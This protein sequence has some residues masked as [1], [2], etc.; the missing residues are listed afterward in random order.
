MGIKHYHIT[1]KMKKNHPSILSLSNRIF[2]LFFLIFQSA[3]LFSQE[4]FQPGFIIT[5]QNDTLFGFVKDRKESPFAKIYKKI[6]FRDESLFTKRFGPDE[7]AGYR[8]GENK[9]ESLWLEVRSKV[10]ETSYWSIPGTGKKEFLKVVVQGYLSYYQLEFT[11]Q[12]S[13][14]FESIPLFKREDK[15]HLI[16]VTQGIFGIKMNSIRDYFN[17]CPELIGK[18]ESGELKRPEEIAR[19]YNRTCGKR[20]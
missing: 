7:I 14:T 3:C 13:A 8:I 16:R 19:Y 20:Q 15:D 5:N 11:D 10:W 1:G 9:Y 18:V 2:F 4:Q 17:D 12:E 6:R